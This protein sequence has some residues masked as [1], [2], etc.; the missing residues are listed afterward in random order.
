MNQKYSLNLS[1]KKTSQILACM[2]TFIAYWLVWWTL[3]QPIRT[4]SEIDFEF[5]CQSQELLKYQEIVPV[6]KKLTQL[7]MSDHQIAKQIGVDPKM[8]KKA[9]LYS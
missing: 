1:L 2:R 3:S 9:K 5:C 7:G 8:I 4:L 6:F